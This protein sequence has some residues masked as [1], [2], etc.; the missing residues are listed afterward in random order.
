MR[1][2]E[3]RMEGIRRR[4]SKLGQLEV[5][6]NKDEFEELFKEVKWMKRKAEQELSQGGGDE[7][8]LVEEYLSDQ[9]EEEEEEE[10]DT[11]RRIIFCSRTHSQLSQF[12]REVRRSSSPSP[13]P[14]PSP[15]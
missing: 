11:A 10:E 12:V 4:R 5:E 14:S 15:R 3:E 1:A 2:R 8:I 7:D 6:Q 9:G 13:S